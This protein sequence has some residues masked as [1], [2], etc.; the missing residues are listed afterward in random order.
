MHRFD[1]FEVVTILV[2]PGEH[3]YVAPK[4]IL[5]NESEFFRGAFNGEW[6]EAAQK[7]VR[8]Q[9]FDSHTFGVFIGWLHTGVLDFS[10]SAAD[11]SN[12]EFDESLSYEAYANLCECIADAFAMG[13]MLQSQ[14]FCNDLVDELVRLIEGAKDLPEVPLLTGMLSMVPQHSTM[15]KLLVDYI[16]FDLK[17]EIFAEEVSVN[18]KQIAIQLR[19]VHS[20]LTNV[21]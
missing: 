7:T 10:E 9:D 18:L 13:D 21:Q 2:G 16:A 4:A 19:V 5:C 12:P 8:L 11:L 15:R 3:E 6:T 17:D 20:E 1:Y 14:R